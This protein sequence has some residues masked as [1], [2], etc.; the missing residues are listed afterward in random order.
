MRSSTW[1]STVVLLTGLIVSCTQGEPTPTPTPSP[2]SATIP[3]PPP[4]ATPTTTPTPPP[5][6]SAPTATPASAPQP[7]LVFSGAQ[8]T[9]DAIRSHQNR[10]QIFAEF[11]NAVL[12]G[13][14]GEGS[15]KSLAATTGGRS[16]TIDIWYE[17]GLETGDGFRLGLTSSF[18]QVGDAAVR[19]IKGNLLLLLRATPLTLSS[20]R[21]AGR[22]LASPARVGQLLQPLE[23]GDAAIAF[24]TGEPEGGRLILQ[25]E[26]ITLVDKDGA[27][28]ARFGFE[29]RNMQQSV[30]EVL[31]SDVP[32]VHEE[33]IAR[34]CGDGALNVSNVSIVSA[35]WDISSSITSDGQTSEEQTTASFI[36]SKNEIYDC[37]TKEYTSRLIIDFTFED[38]STSVQGLGVVSS[39]SSA[40]PTPTPTATP[41]ATP[42]PT[43]TATPTP[44]S[45]PFVASMTSLSCLGSEPLFPGSSIIVYD[46]YIA[47]GTASGP[48]GTILAGTVDSDSCSAWGDDCT[49]GPDDPPT[50]EWQYL[51]GFAVGGEELG[52]F[53]FAIGG[54]F[55]FPFPASCP[56]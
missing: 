18:D 16:D 52:L 25:G 7:E 24:G 55:S 45:I 14:I 19:E 4:S 17:E 3:S 2:T 47:T 49:R 15:F 37:Q 50:T 42:T 48:V 27:T 26:Q 8:I 33:A 22:K 12:D 35:L 21:A 38:G 53:V 29:G 13:Q 31:A 46:S 44:A 40:P 23:Q 5:A 20:R 34:G 10:R 1:L 28:L 43:A 39:P 11:T 51:G 6:G 36:F 32:P 30:Q 9:E 56:G 41:T 54:F